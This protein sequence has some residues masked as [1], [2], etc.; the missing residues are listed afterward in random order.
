MIQPTNKYT[1]LGAIISGKGLKDQIADH[2]Q[3]KQA[4][5]FKFTS[6][7]TKN[8]DAPFA[9]KYKVW[10]S[11]L[12]AATLFSSETWLLNNLRILDKPYLSSLKQMLGVRHTTCNDTIMIELGIGDAQ[13]TVKDI[14][15][16]YLRKV[17]NS[18]SHVLLCNLMAD[19]IAH[20]TPMGR[21]IQNILGTNGDFTGI[22]VQNL[23]NKVRTSTSTRRHDY[24]SLNQTLLPYKLYKDSVPEY[25]RI[26]T[27]RLRLGSH[28]LK[29]ESGRWARIPR[30]NRLCTCKTDI[31]T[32]SHVLL[33][34][35]KTLYLRNS[36]P[37]IKNCNNLNNLFE[38]IDTHTLATYISK[39]LRLME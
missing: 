31:Q 35:P 18:Q 2:L 13:S 16:N 4:H 7:L 15:Y 12:K 26:S 6:F 34:C 17:S 3:S 28:R 8:N 24:V 9:I 11:A 39:V 23:R 27:T 29:I 19:A 37:T 14:Q 21:E 36:I 32:E 22:F 10:D 5:L 1:Y 25:A 33:D 20:N 38:T 30:N